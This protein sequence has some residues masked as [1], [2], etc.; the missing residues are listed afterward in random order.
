MERSADLRHR[1]L[2]SDQLCLSAFA[3]ISGAVAARAQED[4]DD[5]A[6]MRQWE[7][8]QQNPG[9]EDDAGMMGHGGARHCIRQCMAE[10]GMIGHG[11]RKHG[12]MG[13]GG[14]MGPF[15]MRM[16]F[17]L[18]DRD[19]D[20][21]ISLQEFQAAHEIIFKATDSDKDGTVSQEEMLDFM[22]GTAKSQPQ[23]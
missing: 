17:A 18:M 16:I 15:A 7:Q 23:H 1:T 13:R 4:S 9:D 2:S 14:M 3:L 19:G 20:G 11:W 21:T 10:E 12:M 5:A 8:V 6:M 22:R